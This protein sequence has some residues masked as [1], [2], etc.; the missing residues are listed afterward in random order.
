MIFQPIIDA[1]LAEDIGS[2]DVTT[3]ALVPPNMEARLMFNAREPLIMAGGE[4]AAQ[5]FHTLNPS[6][7]VKLLV[8]EGEAAAAGTALLVAEGNAR[9]LLTAE[10]V[11][12][13]L[14]QRACSVATITQCYVDAVAGTGAVILDTRK[15]MPGLRVL[16]KYAVTCGHGQ[17]HRF[18]LYSMV[19]IKDNH[20]GLMDSTRRLADVVAQARNYIE[21]LPDPVPIVIECDTLEQ[22]QQALEASP[23]RILLDNMTLEALRAAVKM[24]NGRIA[25]EASG[26][27]SLET[28][29]AIAETGVDYISVGRITH[30]A[31]SVDIG[32]DISL[33]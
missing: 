13:N 33:H 2:G 17:N 19:L 32:A 3:Q 8:H 22:V 26:G 12:L 7:D 25:L 24:A 15:T 9:T 27:V 1:A 14:L 30:S 11:A 23:S 28:V 10:R 31:P 29:R 20:I 5:V 4:V 6:V 21:K 18:G 16:D